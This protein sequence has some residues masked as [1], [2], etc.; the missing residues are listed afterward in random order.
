M[1]HDITKKKERKLKKKGFG[2]YSLRLNLYIF[3]KIQFNRK[4]QTF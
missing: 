2:S 3:P 1:K 4:I